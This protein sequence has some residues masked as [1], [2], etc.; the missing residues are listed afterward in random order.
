MLR[1]G[2]RIDAE[3]TAIALAEQG[4]RSS[5]VRLPNVHGLGSHGFISGLIAIAR[6]TGVSGHLGD[7]SNRWPSA[8]V[9]DAGR[10]YRLA[11]ES[12]PAGSRLHAV[13][14][15]GVA[16]GEVASLIGRRLDVP[17]AAV[18]SEDAEQ[19][20]GHLSMFLGLDG[21]TSSRITRETLGWARPGPAPWLTSTEHPRSTRGLL[22]SPRLDAHARRRRRRTSTGGHGRSP[23]G[24][25]DPDTTMVTG[26]C[27][28]VP[29]SIS[30]V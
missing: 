4:I 9:R 29:Q 7:G 21:P 11:L 28:A 18:A 13:A 23:T 14:E 24:S 27:A 3:N 26:R 8:D 22:G 10:L 2:P 5:V 20:F 25:Q 17:V 30:R 1:S 12:A 6:A 15:E 19:R 16:L